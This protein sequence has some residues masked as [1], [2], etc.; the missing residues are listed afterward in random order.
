MDD[1]GSPDSKALYYKIQAELRELKKQAEERDKKNYQ[2][3]NLERFVRACYNVTPTAKFCPTRLRLWSDW[4]AKQQEIYSI[5]RTYLQPTEREP[6]RLFSSLGELH[7]LSRG[8]SGRPLQSDMDLHVYERFAVN[9]RVLFII[10]ELRN[11]P[12]AQERFR[13]G[14]GIM[15]KDHANILDEPE[16][17]DAEVR[18]QSCIYRVNDA[19]NA[20]LT[21]VQY[22]LPHKLSVENLRKGLQP[23]DFCTEVVNRDEIPIDHN[24]K[25]IYNAEQLTGSALAQIYHTMI[26][27]GLEYSYIT[28]GLALVFLHIQYHDPSTLYY[29]LCEPNMEIDQDD[30][31]IFQAPLTA[32]SRVLCF[33][34]MSFQSQARGQAWRNAAR[35]Q[36]HMWQTSFD[37]T[38]SQIPIEELREAPPDSE[39]AGSESA[40]SRYRLYLPLQCTAEQASHASSLPSGNLTGSIPHSG[41]YQPRT[42]RFC[43]QRCLLGLQQREELDV[44]CPNFHLHGQGQEGDRHCIDGKQLILT[45]NC[46]AFG[47]CGFYGAVFKITCGAY[48]YTVV[49]KGTMSQRWKDRAQGVAVPVFLGAID[50][51]MTFFRHG[52]G[53]IRHMLLMAWGGNGISKGGR[54]NLYDQISR[55]KRE[56]RELGVMHEDLRLESML[57]N[58]EVGRVMIIDFHRSHIDRRLMRKRK[59]DVG[60]SKRSLLV[61]LEALD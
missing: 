36:L 1:N 56:V 44:F 8:F 5:V 37:H 34:L 28:N 2:P 48:G 31:E 13:L 24:G 25:L 30:A 53:E 60:R 50:L 9:Y 32:I 20:L 45:T 22:K 19:T 59:H 21:I 57:W 18:Q 49:G 12:D 52:A 43:T 14:D 23:M 38:Y 4:S 41:K 46:T 54:L 27:E 61:Y 35:S 51:K 39:Y 33:C 3:T 58:D 16:D 7:L 10:Q 47:D 40:G 42:A 26:Q 11:I 15:F 29:Y 6:D 17:G 55:S